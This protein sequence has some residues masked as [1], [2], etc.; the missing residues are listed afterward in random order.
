MPLSQIEADTLLYQEKKFSED[1]PIGFSKSQ[2]MD[3][4]R[5]LFSTDRREQFF[6]TIERGR[7]KR[8]RLKYQTRARKIIILARIDINGSS[9]LN[10]PNSSHRPNERLTCPHIHLYQEGFDD[11]IAFYPQ[12]IKKFSISNPQD[13]I[14]WLT[15]FLRFCGVH[16]IPNIQT[17]I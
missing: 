16:E 11:R 13:D 2:S 6:L 5:I 8:A 12:E 14:T 17:E 9:H 15:D 7:R 1:T 4:E 10:P 3:F